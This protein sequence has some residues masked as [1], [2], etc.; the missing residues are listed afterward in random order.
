MKKQSSL[1]K[2]LSAPSQASSH[3]LDDRFPD[4]SYIAE[5]LRSFAVPIDL[6]TPNPVNPRQGDIGAVAASL[7]R[8][9]QRKPIVVQAKTGIVY[10]GNHTLAAAK[11]LGWS[12]I[13]A[14][15][16]DADQTDLTAFGIADNRTSDLGTYDDAMLADLLKALAQDGQ[17][18]GTGY[19]GEDVDRLLQDL[20]QFNAEPVNAPALLDGDRSPFRQMTFT[21]HDEQFEEVDA[22]IKKAK[23]E[24]GGESGVNENSNGNALAWICTR[25]NRG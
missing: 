19:D 23:S 18:E 21:V 3:N 11:A 5:P 8:F 20:G 25:F 22:A 13:A 7:K 12:H 14:V 24:G 4:L 6:L 2:K 16:I 15:M 10:A 1:S 17:L 9:S